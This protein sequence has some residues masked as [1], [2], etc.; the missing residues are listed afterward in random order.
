M[1]ILGFCTLLAKY[2]ELNS[3]SHHSRITGKVS[4]I[5]GGSDVPEVNFSIY[6]RVCV[7]ILRSVKLFCC[8][9]QIYI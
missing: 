3:P 4:E 6:W 8:Q 5:P 9:E 1:S 2:P 7:E